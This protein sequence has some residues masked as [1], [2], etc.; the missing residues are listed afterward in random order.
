M[1][2]LEHLEEPEQALA[3]LRPRCEKLVL[4]VNACEAAPRRLFAGPMPMWSARFYVDALHRAGWK[5]THL[6]NRRPA[7]VRSP[8]EW[9]YSVFFTTKPWM[10]ASF[11]LVDIRRVSATQPPTRICLSSIGSGGN[12]AIIYCLS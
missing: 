1:E 2:S 4:R 8:F 9:R 10:Y 5:V 11:P 3:R 12:V 7:S 6:S